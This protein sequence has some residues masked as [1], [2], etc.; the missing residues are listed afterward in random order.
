MTEKQQRR[1]L[2]PSRRHLR[3]ACARAGP[4]M[5]GA[6]MEGRILP[7]FTLF[8]LGRDLRLF[9]S[10]ISDNYNMTGSRNRL[11]LLEEA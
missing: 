8:A 5:E 3:R 4:C 7:F 9:E 11:Y 1:S 6:G 10:S 2:P